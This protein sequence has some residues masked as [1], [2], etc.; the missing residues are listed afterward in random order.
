[1]ADATSMPT[2]VDARRRRLSRRFG[3][4]LLALPEVSIMTRSPGEPTPRRPL[5]RAVSKLAP[6]A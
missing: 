3:A 1:M 4:V 5:G 6:P 2:S